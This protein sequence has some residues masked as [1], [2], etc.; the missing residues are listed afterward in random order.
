MNNPQTPRQWQEVGTLFNAGNNTALTIEFQ[1]QKP[2]ANGTVLVVNSV[3]VNGTTQTGASP[4]TGI[5]LGTI[6]PGAM[7]TVVFKVVVEC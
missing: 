1:S 3:T 5:N 4:Q 6:A 2:V 7:T